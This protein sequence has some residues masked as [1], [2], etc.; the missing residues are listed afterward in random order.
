[1]ITQAILKENL[2][3]D[4]HTGIF[5]WK[6]SNN[7]RIKVGDVAGSETTK[8]YLHIGLKGKIHKSHRLAWLYVYGSMPTKEIDHIDGDKLNNKI[9]NLRQ[10]SRSEN[11][12]NVKVRKNNTSGFCGVYWKGELNK[13][14]VLIQ[15][16]GKTKYIGIFS[17]LS[18]AV[19]A[20][21]DA[22]SRS[23]YHDNNGSQKYTK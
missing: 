20:R 12:K 19:K 14:M 18:D 16:F 6:K 10:V 22:E 9:S 4:S 2:N 13:W 15:S 3:Y 1:M 11:M 23:G 21:I 17:D 8:G 5:S 7:G